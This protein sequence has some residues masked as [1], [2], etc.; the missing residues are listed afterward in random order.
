MGERESVSGKD[1]ILAVVA[2]Y[3][4]MGRI[5][6][7]ITPSCALRGFHSATSIT[8]PFGA[9]T[10]TGKILDFNPELMLHALSIAGSHAAGVTEYDQGG[11]SVKRMHAGMAAHGGMKSALLARKG[12]TGPPA[13]LE[14]KHGFCK[15]FADDYDLTQ[16][17][18]GLGKDFR[19]TL[20]SCIKAYCAC[21]GMH[22]GIDAM[23]KILADN[24]F[25]AADI[26]EITMGTNRRTISHVA[27]EPTD[28]TSAQFSTGFGLALTT[29]RGGNGF[30]DY[31]EET[32]RDP[33]ILALAGKVKL[34]IDK[35]VDSEYPAT[36]GARVTVKLN[37]GAIYQEKVD[38]CKGTPQNPMTRN[39]LE[40]KFH[41]LTAV[42]ADKSKSDEIIRVVNTL[43]GHKNIS[44]LIALLS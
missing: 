5:N 32:L 41:G 24:K 43:D 16:I 22:A 3:E 33:A 39:E 18:A 4:V 40:E 37:N 31:T 14:G 27:A 36:R 25:K 17:T 19:V 20:G 10:V 35:Q 28:I 2:G 13:I 12:L 38:Y 15:A 9:A 11:G 26:K 34:E 7:A 29:I 21:A 1:V 44:S 6:A 30:K 42:V 8:G 23:R